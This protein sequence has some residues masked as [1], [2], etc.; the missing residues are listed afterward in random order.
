MANACGDPVVYINL[1][2]EYHKTMDLPFPKMSDKQKKYIELLRNGEEDD[3]DSDKESQV[4][5]EKEKPTLEDNYNIENEHSSDNPMAQI[6]KES[7]KL[8]EER[9]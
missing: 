1:M 8:K 5:S 6:K 7:V 3:R 2:E 9:K 4:I